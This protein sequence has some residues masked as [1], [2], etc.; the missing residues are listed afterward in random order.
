MNTQKTVPVG[1]LWDLPENL[2]VQKGD[3]VSIIGGYTII[4]NPKGFWINGKSNYNLTAD[5]VQEGKVGV[6]TKKRADEAYQ[7]A[8]E[9]GEEIHENSV[10]LVFE[11]ESEKLYWYVTYGERTWLFDDKYTAFQFMYMIFDVKVQGILEN[12]QD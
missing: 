11:L 2:V 1:H 4:S 10:H 9:K 5:L 6:I 7:I 12:E 8:L 3:T